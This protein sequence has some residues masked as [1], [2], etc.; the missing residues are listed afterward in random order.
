MLFS[1]QFPVLKSLRVFQIPSDVLRTDGIFMV[2]GQDCLHLICKA[3][4]LFLT[5]DIKFQIPV[6]AKHK[7]RS[8]FLHGITRQK[9]FFLPVDKRHAPICMS[10]DLDRLKTITAADK[11]VSFRKG[12]KF[13]ITFYKMLVRFM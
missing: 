4:Q 3:A 12:F 1:G 8:V 2:A 10:G 11:H 6:I 13:Y 7:D 9:K 5:L